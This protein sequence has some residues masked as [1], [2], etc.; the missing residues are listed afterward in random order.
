MTL[1][2]KPLKVVMSANCGL[3]IAIGRLRTY[4]SLLGPMFRSC[5]VPAHG[6][7]VKL[8]LGDQ[9]ICMSGWKTTTRPLLRE[10]R[11]SPIEFTGLTVTCRDCRPSFSS[12]ERSE[13][14]WHRAV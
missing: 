12:E 2:V 5:G 8:G 6:C 14:R 7:L 13:A 1:V 4:R 3:R 9:W 10:L 11:N